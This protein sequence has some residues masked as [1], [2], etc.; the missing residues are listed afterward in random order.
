VIAAGRLSSG[1][2]ADAAIQS[3]QADLVGLAR[4]LWADPQWPGKVAAGREAE[5]IHCSPDCPDVCTQMVMKGRPALCTQWP[6][7]KTAQ[8]KAKLAS[9]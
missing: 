7:E 9:R 8:W 1:A 4:V 5:I 6:P 3:G 2:L